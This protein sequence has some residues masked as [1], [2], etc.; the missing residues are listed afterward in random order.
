MWRF[1]FSFVSEAS[2]SAVAHMIKVVHNG[3]IFEPMSTDVHAYGPDSSY[4]CYHIHLPEGLIQS[5]AEA[6]SPASTGTELLAYQGYNEAN[7]ELTANSEP[8][9]IPI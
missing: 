5:R 2:A 6:A 9:S 8:S 7:Q 3:K 4:R 1:W